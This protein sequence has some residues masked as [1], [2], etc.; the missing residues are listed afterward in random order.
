MRCPVPGAPRVRRLLRLGRVI[1][2]LGRL[3]ADWIYMSIGSTSKWW[4]LK[5]LRSNNGVM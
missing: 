5:W 4:F 3:L 1:R 2:L